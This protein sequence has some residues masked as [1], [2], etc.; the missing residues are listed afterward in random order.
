MRSRR[1]FWCALA[2][3]AALLFLIAISTTLEAQAPPHM[4]LPFY[5]V[6]DLGT[7]GGTVSFAVGVNDRGVVSLD[8]LLSG[9]SS[10][11][12]AIW[13]NG[14]KTDLGTLGGPNSLTFWRPSET[15]LVTGFSD[16]TAP[17]PLGEDFCF[18]GTFLECR[19]FVWQNGVMTP[20]PTL[21][22]NNSIASAINDFGTV[23]GYSENT[24]FDRTCPSPEYEAKP[25]IW[26]HGIPQELP[27][28]L[29]D[30]DGYL[31][32]INNK[33]QV[34][35]GSGGCNG[36]PSKHALLWQNGTV[37][38]LGNL[39]GKLF[40]VANTLNDEG[41][42]IGPSDLPGD[43]NYY[44]QPGASSTAHAF[45]WKNG[46][47][48]DLGALP[49]DVTS[50]P[51][52]INNRGQIVGGGSRA[53]L[54][55][56]RDLI[57]LNTLVRGGPFSPLYLLSANGINDHGEIVGQGLTRNGDIHAFLAIPCDAEH[58]SVAGC[59]PGAPAPTGPDA[60]QASAVND[61]TSTNAAA[62]R[63]TLR[64]A[65]TPACPDTRLLSGRYR[66][67]FACGNAG[68]P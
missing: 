51:N 24:N 14:R 27:T 59:E 60:A 20:L 32:G 5:V 25:V 42:V 66:P 3:V 6:L 49:G 31:N 54:W 35:G 48:T 56:D 11:Q 16:T 50:V 8:S 41:A 57:D 1:R 58:S 68:R 15:G 63:R 52:S 33:G 29:G 65:G 40:T 45:V 53:I 19:G 28:F 23:A 47:M 17:D 13:V 37:T 36:S 62:V 9:D 46:V 67:T 21:G 55:Q 22:G 7:L 30:P 26:D 38:D 43:T 4:D 39:G 64:R 2:P 61:Q 12:V 34:V 44:L 10:L 18:F